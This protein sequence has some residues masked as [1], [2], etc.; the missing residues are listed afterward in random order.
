MKVDGSGSQALLLTYI[1]DDKDR[2]FDIE[3][4]G[5][6]LTTVEWKGGAT[7]KFYDVEYPLPAAMTAGKKSIRVKVLANHGKTAG[8][9]FGVRTMRAE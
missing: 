3:V 2:I 4:D 8:R 5:V 6:K 9:V 7:G 1:G